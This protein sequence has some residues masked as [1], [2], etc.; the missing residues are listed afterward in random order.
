MQDH[1]HGRQGH[2]DTDRTQPKSGE[3]QRGQANEP[4]QKKQHKRA[5]RATPGSHVSTR[6]RQKPKMPSEAARSP[7]SHPLVGDNMAKS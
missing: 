5:R 1:L 7:R 3:Q 6:V 2:R 4:G